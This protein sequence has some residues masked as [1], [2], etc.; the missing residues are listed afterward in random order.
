MSTRPK[1]ATKTCKE[2]ETTYDTG[3]GFFCG[4]RCYYTHKG[5]KALNNLKHDHRLCANCGSWLKQV[6][7]PTDEWRQLKGSALQVALEN[8]GILTKANGKQ[9][10]DYTDVA[11]VGVIP[12]DSVCGFEHAT[13]HA[14]NVH[15]EFQIDEYRSTFGTGLGC[16]CGVTDPRD[17]DETLRKIELASVLANYVL[18]F[19]EFY[20]EGQIDQQISKKQFFNTFKESQDIEYSLGKALFD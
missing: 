16:K 2:C 3:Y 19:R 4:E 15:K 18:V 9:I 14:E 17:I 6:S 1:Q 11:D 5:E 8:G 20:Q 13:E 7:R 12:V 10:L